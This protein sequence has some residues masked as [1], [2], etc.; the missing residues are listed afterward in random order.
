MRSDARIL[1]SMTLLAS[2][3][4][5][6]PGP[7]LAEAPVAQRTAH[8]A[9]A[10]SSIQHIVVLMQE[11]R[12]FDH[13]FG[14]LYAQGQPDALPVPDDASNPDPTN[15]GGPPITPFHQTRYC[16]VHDL[17]HSWNGTHKQWN[18]GRMDGFTATNQVPEDPTGSRA[19]GFYDQSDLPFYY[20]LY[21]TFAIGDH[22][23]S[24]TLTQTFPNRF[25]LLA[26]TSFGH[27][28]NDLPGPGQFN[29]RTIFN[30]LDEARPPIS[31]KV[32]YSQVP[33][34]YEF[35]YVREQHPEKARPIQ[36]YFSDAAAGTLPQ[37]S[38]VDPIFAG[39]ANVENDEH[40][41]SNIQVGQRFVSDVVNALFRSPNW[42]SSAFFLTYD[43]H[44][45]FFDHLPP[46]LAPVPDAIPPML[47]PGDV[48]G[49]FDR[50]GMRVPMA[51]VSPFA[52]PHHVSHA[53]YDHTSIL[54]F[55]ETRFG[56]PALT[57]RDGR[58][59]PML[60]LFDFSSPSFSTPPTLAAA[61]I[62]RARAAEC[63][64]APPPGP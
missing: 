40:P 23:F 24:S 11:N 44:G 4:A 60:D 47:R 56:L 31:W 53:V 3:L 34:A 55:I 54:R 17:D 18:G 63:A 20:D 30:L 26:G 7:S 21:S 51:M 1:L 15:P 19:M 37:V 59:D 13:Y 64:T 62:D 61:Q 43:E 22:F 28:R 8:P 16:E 50:Y 58:A 2:V 29:Q 5:L 38:F 35:A 32:Y 48:P 46:P 14:Q 25:Y 57:N 45:G 6:A 52:K 42:G 41:P 39:P 12:P 27:I 33:F 49:G 36:E 9:N 10:Q